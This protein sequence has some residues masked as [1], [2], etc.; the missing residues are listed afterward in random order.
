MLLRA[1][2]KLVQSAFTLL[3]TLFAPRYDLVAWLVSRGDWQDWG[4]TSLVYLRAGRVLEL[5]SGPGHLLAPLGARA[6]LAVGLEHSPAMIRLASSRR[7]AGVLV[8]GDARHMPFRADAFTTVVSTFPTPY[9]V[10]SSTLD[11]VERVLGPSGRLVI[12][13][14]ADL[15]DRDPYTWLVNLAFALTSR[16][17]AE[18]PLPGRLAERGFA[19]SHHEHTT[20]HGRVSVLVAEK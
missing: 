14:G 12:V 2:A 7:G 1:W 5:G 13:D 6:T 9:I 16:P 15:T 20:R 11:E 8:Q 17:L 4:R 3:Y 10:A 18:S 19:L